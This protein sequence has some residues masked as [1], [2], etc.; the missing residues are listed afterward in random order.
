MWIINFFRAKPMKSIRVLF[1]T[2]SK[3]SYGE[4]SPETLSTGLSN[5]SSH[6]V[7][8]FKNHPSIEMDLVSVIDNNEIDKEVYQ[9]KP[10]VVVIEALW[11]VP[12]KFEVLRKLHPNVKWVVRLHSNAPFISGEG[13]AFDWISQYLETPSVYVS[14]NNESMQYDIQS[15]F[16]RYS[17]KVLYMPNIYIIQ[18]QPKVVKSPIVPREINIGCFGAIRILKNQLTQALAAIEYADSRDLRL[19]YHINAS[20]IE[21]FTSDNILKNIRSIFAYRKDHELV[22]HEWMPQEDFK[23]LIKTMDIGLQV[24]LTETFNM[25]SGDFISM[26]V[27]VIVSEEISWV[28]NST[29][30]SRPTSAKQISRLIDRTIQS[31]KSAVLDSLDNLDV[32][33]KD[34][35]KSW[36][37]TL[38]YLVK[39]DC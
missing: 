28:S 1:I 24:S 15:V 38:K 18:K 31:K 4:V 21:G 3:N 14:C 26:G 10:D 36:I 9:Y 29:K 34:A 13:I 33:N 2:K 5:S 32:S 25:V 39:D 12:S 22:E 17:D 27:P 35:K 7:E 11:V 8:Y 37:E 6:I 19:R 16:R 23:E 30:S 20:R